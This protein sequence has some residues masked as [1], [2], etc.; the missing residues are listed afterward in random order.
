MKMNRNQITTC[1]DRANHLRPERA[2]GTRRH[3]CRAFRLTSR[4]MGTVMA[5]ILMAVIGVAA[6]GDLEVSVR[7]PA[8][9]GRITVGDPVTLTVTLR[10]P[11]GASA[12][13]LVRQFP[14]DVSLLGEDPL[15]TSLANGRRVEQRRLRLA[16]FRPG[17]ISSGPIRYTTVA[18]GTSLTGESPGV[19]VTIHSVLTGSDKTPAA[20]ASPWIIPYP[21]RRLVLLL[22]AAALL[23][24]LLVGGIIL[25]RRRKRPRPV[26][27]DLPPHLVAR[28]R[29]QELAAL[30]LPGRG[31]WADFHF[32]ISEIIKA[33][34]G[35]EL[36]VSVLERTTSEI[37]AQLP[38]VTA[39]DAATRDQVE[40]FLVEADRVKYA[41]CQ[42]T[43]AAM[44]ATMRSALEIVTR[45]HA[46]V[47]ALRRSDSSP[48]DGAGEVAS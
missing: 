43:L 11:E 30:D 36:G 29:L 32:R 46:G 26:L 20:A 16:F 31:E 45:A 42:P 13:Q 34:L 7:G 8:A 12:P 39:L 22:V 23:L 44:E 24:G 17:K 4:L 40:R 3:S 14:D 15:E 18:A 10:Y 33:Y 19:T 27:P 35:R 6:G 41:R 9:G 5:M 48:A 37:A 21:T 2:A 28:R 1:M 38:R 25:W 47:E